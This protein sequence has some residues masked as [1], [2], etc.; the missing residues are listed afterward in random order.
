MLAADAVELSSNALFVVPGDD[1]SHPAHLDTVTTDGDLSGDDTALY[2][3]GRAVVSKQLGIHGMD[4]ALNAGMVLTFSYWHGRDVKD[5]D[6]LNSPPCPS[7]VSGAPSCP[8]HVIF[9][10]I[11]IG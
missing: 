6:W 10:D 1:S 8:D 2:Q 4:A 11:S 3:D 7:G 5:M 9:G